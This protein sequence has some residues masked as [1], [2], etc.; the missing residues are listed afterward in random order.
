[1]V[2][3]LC[4]SEVYVDNKAVSTFQVVVIGDIDSNM[5]M[6]SI[7]ET[8]QSGGSDHTTG[9][10]VW[11]KGVVYYLKD[12]RIVGAML[13]NLADHKDD[14]I[15]LLRTGTKYHHKSDQGIPE[16]ETAIDFGLVDPI[17]RHSSAK[18][19]GMLRSNNSGREPK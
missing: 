11:D 3:L 4:A 5:E 7:A 8:H 15:H 19:I 14:V 10:D 17:C 18:G 6:Y 9:W 12:R 2:D 1:M 16:L 13:L